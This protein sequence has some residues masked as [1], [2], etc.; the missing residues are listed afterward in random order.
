MYVKSDQW[1][2]HAT[3]ID[4]Y[5]KNILIPG[6]AIIAVGTKGNS[7]EYPDLTT[8]LKLT[9]YTPFIPSESLEAMQSYDPAWTEGYYDSEFSN[10]VGNTVT[11]L[12]QMRLQLYM[13]SL[14]SKK[15][16]N[17]K[18]LSALSGIPVIPGKTLSPINKLTASTEKKYYLH[19]DSDGLDSNKLDISG[20]GVQISKYIV[21]AD[22]EGNI[23]LNGSVILKKTEGVDKL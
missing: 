21:S 17:I 1:S 11:N 22:P 16:V 20:G 4:K 3:A 14:D 6:G 12:N 9:M 2:N 15:S 23:L 18:S 13:D 19:D 10:L 7:S 5:G 8:T